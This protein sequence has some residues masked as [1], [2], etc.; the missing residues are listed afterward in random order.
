MSQAVT[1][2]TFQSALAT[3][4]QAIEKNRDSLFFKT[5]LKSCETVLGDDLLGVAI[6]KD[7]PETPHDYYTIR[8]DE[9]RFFLVEHGRGDVDSDWKVSED[10][11]RD[12]ANDPDK[13]VDHPEKLSLNWLANRVSS[14]T[15]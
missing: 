2:D 6:Y 1:V 9:G 14:A 10:Y 11:L 5:L 4:N 13:Y 12:L 3:M 7:S 8:M 15:A